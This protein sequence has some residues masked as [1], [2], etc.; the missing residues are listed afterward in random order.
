MQ[1]AVSDGSLTNLT[2]S[3]PFSGTPAV[4]VFFDSTE[5]YSGWSLI[6]GVVHFT[7][8][9]TSG[10]TVRVWR[11]T[12][13]SAVPYEFTPGAAQFT[14]SNIDENFKRDLYITQEVLEQRDNPLPDASYAMLGTV[15]TWT[16]SQNFYGS[17]L[18]LT[19]DFWS[20]T[21]ANRLL[22]QSSTANQNTLLG[23][24]P[25]GTATTSGYNAYNSSDP[26][27]SNVCQITSTSTSSNLI[28]HGNG[29]Q[30][31]L[32]LKLKVGTTD[33]LT[34]TTTG[35][36]T[37]PDGNTGISVQGANQHLTGGL[38]GMPWFWTY[39]CQWVEVWAGTPTSTGVNMTALTC[40]ALSGTYLV[41]T[42]GGAYLIVPFVSGHASVGPAVSNNHISE[43]DGV[44]LSTSAANSTGTTLF[45]S[46]YTINLNMVQDSYVP[47][48][49][50]NIYRLT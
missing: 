36:I 35:G 19:G 12:D 10:V 18:R 17:G 40:G 30:P 23:T 2:L 8:A 37:A 49:I 39:A 9:V 5:Q 46:S 11:V 32:P 34:L 13:A 33:V 26:T 29:T 43:D 24:I 21:H 15:N 7:T 16:A 45:A 50:T 22:F 47:L 27:N 31:T 41:R 28:S 6:S 14:A 25:N 48:V 3:F 42:D 4:R 20:D 38:T 44:L 1:Y